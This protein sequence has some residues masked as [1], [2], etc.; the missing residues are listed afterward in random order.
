[1]G[2]HL[3][4]RK[5]TVSDGD[6]HLGILIVE[7]RAVPVT[8]AECLAARLPPVLLRGGIKAPWPP[9]AAAAGR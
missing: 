1:M 7:R 3:A 8:R 2:S 9:T 5:V 4:A 6:R